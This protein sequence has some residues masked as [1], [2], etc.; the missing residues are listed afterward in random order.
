MAGNPI[1]FYDRYDQCVKTERVYGETGLRIAYGTPPGRFMTWAMF[2]RPWFSRL[3][4]WQMKRPSSVSKIQPFIDKYG[5]NTDEFAWPVEDYDSFNSFF[6]RELKEGARPIAGDPTCVVFPADGRH[7]GWQV[8]GEEE[9]VFVKGQ[10]WDLAGLLDED[11]ALV[12]RYAGGTMVLSRLCPVDYHHFHYP[13]G[14]QVRGLRWM[15]QDLY[16]V[17]PIALRKR[18]SYFWLNKRC[19]T[20]IDTDSA[21][22]VCFMEVG[23]TN[24]GS[25]HHREAAQGTVVAKGDPKGW[26]EF[27][28]SS[29]V[30]LFEPERIQ[31]DDDLILKTQEGIELY[32]HVGDH[33]GTMVRENDRLA[34]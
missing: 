20:L 23:A 4:G 27:G 17:S 9:R 15:G 29:V 33:M 13:V 1:Q 32:A 28:G 16:S 8:L 19:M 5:L 22:L 30:T 31:L 3:F 6:I 34:P 25:I 24:V 11:P 12:K 10:Q 14:G 26:F 2:A 18:L 7:M 21:G